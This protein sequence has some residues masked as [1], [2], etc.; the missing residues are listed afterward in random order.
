MFKGQTLVN[1]PSN[2][3]D[4]TRV[5]PSVI[6]VRINTPTEGD[7]RYL[8]GDNRTSPSR[9]LTEYMLP[10]DTYFGIRSVG[11]K[12]TED[13]ESGNTS[14]NVTNMIFTTELANTGKTS[15]RSQPIKDSQ[16]TTGSI[17]INLKVKTKVSFMYTVRSEGSYDF[18]EGYLAGA[19]LF[20]ISGS[21]GWSTFSRELE[22]GEHKFDFV[23]LKDGSRTVLPDCGFIDNFS[24]ELPSQPIKYLVRIAG[25]LYYKEGTDWKVA[26]GSNYEAVNTYG[27]ADMS[28]VS[29]KDE[30]IKNNEIS[31]L[32]LSD[33]RTEL[34]Y[35]GGIKLLYRYRLDLSGRKMSNWSEWTLGSFNEIIRV[36]ASDMEGNTDKTL[37]VEFEIGATPYKES[38]PIHIDSNAPTIDIKQDMQE[39]TVTVEDPE[40]DTVKVIVMMNGVQVYPTNNQEPTYQSTPNVYFK[41]F[42]SSELEPGKNNIMEVI[43]TD[44]YGKQTKVKHEFF[45]RYVGLMF[46]DDKHQYYSTDLG[47]LLK[48]LVMSPKII[49]GAVTLPSK[50]Y[51]TNEY[52]FPVTNVKLYSDDSPDNTTVVFSKTLEPFT[53]H[54]VLDMGDTEYNINEGFHFFVR[55]QSHHSALNGG[56]FSIVVEAKGD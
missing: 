15:L 24:L 17:V 38:K 6:P 1:F 45:A 5:S 16:R 40:G 20:R 56:T 29:D 12:V 35:M 41:N 42:I 50:V 3:N 44:Y 22:A 30:F 10:R 39:F 54:L 19:R 31:V 47:E 32:L 8:V 55:V 49:A 48:L 4:V 51:V 26:H 37:S 28:L 52:G 9:M 18:F 25:T 7:V 21:P 53:D 23:Y 13:F 34:L 36:Y 14:L 33:T 2:I 43:A 46:H 27:M 11:Y